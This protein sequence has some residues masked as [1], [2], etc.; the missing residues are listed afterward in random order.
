MF[1]QVP[2]RD[3]IFD[4]VVTRH[5]YNSSNLDRPSEESCYASKPQG[6][7]Q[8]LLELADKD[9]FSKVKSR[10]NVNNNYGLSQAQWANYITYCQWF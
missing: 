9:N 2:I 6:G 5:K 7:G 1:K 10:Y 3:K 4:T 8:Q